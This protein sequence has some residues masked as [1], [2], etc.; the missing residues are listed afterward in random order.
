MGQH[1]KVCKR[2]TKPATRQL[3]AVIR[4]AA[5]LAILLFYISLAFLK[6]FKTSDCSSFILVAKI[7]ELIEEFLDMN[8]SNKTHRRLCD[9]MLEQLNLMTKS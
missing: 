8:D 4:N 9:F 7:A 2:A 1:F 3:S 5:D 6:N